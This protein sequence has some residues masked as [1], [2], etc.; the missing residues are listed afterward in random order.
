LPWI[1]RIFSRFPIF[2]VLNHQCLAIRIQ[3]LISIILL[4]H[5]YPWIAAL[6]QW[7]Y[8][9]WPSHYEI[10]EFVICFFLK[11]WLKLLQTFVHLSK[12]C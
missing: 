11:L 12:P 8:F 5:L 9:P 1:G 4:L 7:L 2:F 3:W 10:S 6:I